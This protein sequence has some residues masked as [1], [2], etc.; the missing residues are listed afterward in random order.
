MFAASVEVGLQEFEGDGSL[1][2][3][4]DGPRDL[5]KS[6][7]TRYGPGWEDLQKER[8]EKGLQPLKS[9]VGSDEDKYRR[10]NME[11]KRQIAL[12]FA[13]LKTYQPVDSIT[14]LLATFDNGKVEKVEI[15]NPGSGYTYA[16]GAEAPRVTF[17]QPDA[18]EGY[19]VAKGRAV[20]RPNGK[21]LRIDVDANLN[22]GGMGYSVGKPPAVTISP[23][24]AATGLSSLKAATAKAFVVRD[25]VNKGKIER[26]ELTNPGI[27]YTEEDV[28]KVTVAT[29]PIDPMKLSGN[30]TLP[31][32][33]FVAK[34]VLE[35]EV[36]AIEITSSGSGYATEKPLEV[37]VDPPSASE[38]S[39]STSIGSKNPVIAMA[40]PVADSDSYKS[41]RKA[42]D[43]KVQ[44]FENTLLKQKLSAA[45][46][47]TF[48]KT[49]AFWRGGNTS[50]AQLLSLLPAGIGLVY[51]RERSL[52]EIVTGDDVLN[53]DWAE[54]M[55]PRKPIDPDF[56]PRGRSP[57]EREKKLDN[58]TLLRFYLAGALCSSSVHLVLTP[59]DVVKTNMQTKPEK[60]T[61]P[62]KA[63]KIVLEEKGF[64]GFFAGWV[65]TFLGF[66]INGGIAYTA[67]EFFRRYYTE[68]LGDSAPNYEIPIILA[69]SFTAAVI[70]VF[71]LT[72]SEAIRIRSVAQPDYGSNVIDVTKRMIEEEGLGSLFNAIPAFL[73][74]EIPFVVAKFTVFDL[75]TDYLYDAFP[76]AREDL[77]LSLLVSLAGGTMGGITAALVSN[78]ADATI[79]EM[80][81]AKTD[82]GPLVIFQ[83]LAKEGGAKALFRGLGVRMVFYTL[84]CS[85]QFLV[86]DAIRITLGVGNDDLKLYLDVLGGALRETGG[87]I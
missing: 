9:G 67:I 48:G 82:D 85:G 36:G 73:L 28:I 18:G 31:G 11:A 23:P 45:G 46:D 51:N 29:P 21:V 16:T 6:L 83:R 86:Y 15:V 24:T 39:D 17:P 84:I 64:T 59:I 25:G 5:M 65:P 54:S 32:Q 79:S 66:F 35:Y 38:A 12:L 72:P 44:A 40:Y 3:R 8:I 74:K 20:L 37:I 13:L 78:P 34:A 76:A 56:G 61:D 87:P 1:K 80:K 2:G 10:E 4:S 30:S 26:I 50:S 58:G 70:G 27:G 41:F 62:L 55:S 47:E 71:T 75:A 52:Y 49:E 60:Y 43:N 22:E 14:Q 68:L 69:S 81:K 33:F 53:Y 42:N 57:I 7:L 63:F 77:K 19:E